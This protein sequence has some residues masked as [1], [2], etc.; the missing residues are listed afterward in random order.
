M[1]LSSL[2]SEWSRYLLPAAC[3]AVVAALAWAW[4]SRRRGGAGSLARW[5]IDDIHARLRDAFVAQRYQLVEKA[6]RSAEGNDLVLRRGHETFLVWSKPWTERRVGA[7]A[8]QQLC[9]AMNA[10]GATGGF[11]VTTGRFGRDAIALAATHNV[12]LIDGR[13][14]RGMLVKPAR[15][16]GG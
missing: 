14:L 16:T 5:S 6:P 3:V 12:R 2:W 7:D 13:T 4:C 8:V 1:S 11:V 15:A 9:R 10:R